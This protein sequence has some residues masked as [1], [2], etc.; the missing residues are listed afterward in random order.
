MK[1]TISN[2]NIESLD[3]VS[4]EASHWRVSHDSVSYAVTVVRYFRTDGETVYGGF[5]KCTSNPGYGGDA[6][7]DFYSDESEALN[8]LLRRVA[9]YSPRRD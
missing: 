8:D 5:F 4:Q 1:H 9:S 3:E 2:E 6:C 7:G